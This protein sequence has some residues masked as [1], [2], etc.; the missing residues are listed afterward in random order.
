MIEEVWSYLFPVQWSH[1]SCL[2]WTLD[3]HTLWYGYIFLLFQGLLP[4]VWV[5]VSQSFHYCWVFVVSAA[6]RGS[7]VS[8][9]SAAEGVLNCWVCTL[10]G[11]GGGL[12]A[13]W[14]CTFY[15]DLTFGPQQV[16]TKFPTPH[17][18]QCRCFSDLLLLLLYFFYSSWWLQVLHTNSVHRNYF[19]LFFCSL[20]FA[21]LMK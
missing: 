5:S 6:L 17:H 11:G 16:F 13:S 21:M 18:L 4:P 14:L 2:L 12:A 20:F 3:L 8:P 1:P 19:V 15:I 7:Q 10:G 9:K